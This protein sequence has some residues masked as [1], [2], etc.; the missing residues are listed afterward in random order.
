[1]WC[2]LI[3]RRPDVKTSPLLKIDKSSASRVTRVG[4]MSCANNFSAI[5]T[6]QG[7]HDAGDTR[8]TCRMLCCLFLALLT[9]SSPVDPIAQR[10]VVREACNTAETGN[11]SYI[12]TNYVTT[13]GLY[14]QPWPLDCLNRSPVQH[15]PS[16]H[17][18]VLLRLPET[19]WQE[20][21]LIATH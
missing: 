13:C 16:L 5:V 14:A 21:L 1:M 7:W 17:S 19:P 9:A 20:Q 18:A 4:H 15:L 11:N 12:T 3:W 8:I 2:R 10:P 6:S